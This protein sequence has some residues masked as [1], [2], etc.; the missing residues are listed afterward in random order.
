MTGVQTCALPIL[1]VAIGSRIAIKFGAV[2]FIAK[3]EQEFVQRVCPVRMFAVEDVSPRDIFVIVFGPSHS[4]VR[5]VSEVLPLFLLSNKFAPP[6]NDKM[7]GPLAANI[8]AT[9]WEP[10]AVVF[11][12]RPKQPRTHGKRKH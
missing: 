12:A 10:F 4:S 9:L 8:K 1:L 7:T 5:L 11:A 3:R 2:G 6:Q